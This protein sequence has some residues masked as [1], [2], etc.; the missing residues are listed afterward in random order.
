MAGSLA[1]NAPTLQGCR[2][3]SAGNFSHNLS[4]FDYHTVH[5]ALFSRMHI[6]ECTFIIK[7]YI[8]LLF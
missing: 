2:Y 4:I 6:L 3:V 1:V 8:L 7:K 5:D